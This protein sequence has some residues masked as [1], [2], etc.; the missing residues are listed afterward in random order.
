MSAILDA[1][2]RATSD[3]TQHPLVAQPEPFITLR[4]AAEQLGLPY[5]KLQRAARLGLFPTYSLF[6]KRKLCRL[7]EVVAAI[8]RSHLGGRND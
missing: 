6:N 7:S 2:L 3:P 5:F 1:T 8:E 4:S